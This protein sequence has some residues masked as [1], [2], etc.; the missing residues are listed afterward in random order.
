MSLL[1]FYTYLLPNT[2]YAMAKESTELTHKGQLRAN[3]EDSLSITYREILSLPTSRIE[4][5]CPNVVFHYYSVQKETRF[6]N[7]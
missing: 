4:P 2:Y 6:K 5:E 3:G 7:M 1:H